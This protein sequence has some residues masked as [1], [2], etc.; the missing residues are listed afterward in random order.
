MDI[1]KSFIFF[2]Y[3]SKKKKNQKGG[4]NNSNNLNMEDATSTFSEIIQ[5]IKGGLYNWIAI[6]LIIGV[7]FP[8]IPFMFVMSAMFGI[9]NYFI[10]FF[11]YF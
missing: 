7:M 8:A 6:P 11:K 5:Y 3:E 1:I 10:N 2:D 4:A 9:F